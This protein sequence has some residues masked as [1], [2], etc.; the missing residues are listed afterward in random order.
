MTDMLTLEESLLLEPSTV[1]EAAKELATFVYESLITCEKD[2]P[3][4]HRDYP[5]YQRLR[6]QLPAHY[7]LSF[8]YDYGANLTTAEFDKA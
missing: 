3:P 4:T 6:A 8:L 7:T 1:Q 2:I 5:T